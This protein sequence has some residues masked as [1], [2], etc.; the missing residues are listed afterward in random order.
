VTESSFAP[1]EG[2]KVTHIGTGELFGHTGK[3]LARAGHG[4]HVKWATGPKTGCVTMVDIDDLV[5]ANATHTAA[6]ERDELEDSL[7]VGGLSFSAMQHMQV[8]EGTLGVLHFAADSGYL[9][10]FGDIA[11]DVFLHTAG[12]LRQ[13][14][15]FREVLA[16]LDENDG[17]ALVTLATRSL[18]R[19]A[20]GDA[21]E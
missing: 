14:P 18:L 2:S 13:D 15:A 7:E 6:V 8:V 10:N 5:P 4:G 16:Q 17:D 3:L 19:D 21:D 12:Q 20:F 11:E 9:V 1:P